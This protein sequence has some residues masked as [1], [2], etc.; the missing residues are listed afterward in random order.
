MEDV[1]KM[2]L[3][4]GVPALPCVMPDIVPSF[5]SDVTNR[6]HFSPL[7]PPLPQLPETPAP[8]RSQIVSVGCK[9]SNRANFRTGN[10]GMMVAR[11]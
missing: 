9:Q 10:L 8:Q 4:P 7:P 6:R 3:L 11:F 1:L 5:L 2:K